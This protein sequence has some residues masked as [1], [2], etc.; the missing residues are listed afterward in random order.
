MTRKDYEL[1]AEALRLANGSIT[2]TPY[3]SGSA[4]SLV[5]VLLADRLE[6]ENPR[7][8]RARFLSA[9]EVTKN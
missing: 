7:F 9:C 1:I 2:V 3:D 4:L 5:S 6:K 8:N